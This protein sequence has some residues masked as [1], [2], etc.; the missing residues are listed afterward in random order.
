LVGRADIFLDIDGWF[1]CFQKEF[2]CSANAEAVIR[3]FYDTAYFNRIFMDYIFLSL[4]IALL[5]VNIPTESIKEGVDKFLPNL[6]LV[7]F[8]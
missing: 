8:A 5:V 4:R 7:V 6:G 1:L 3:G 2:P